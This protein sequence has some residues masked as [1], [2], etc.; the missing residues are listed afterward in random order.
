MPLI[1]T[2]NLRRL[3]DAL[4]IGEDTIDFIGRVEF[5]EQIGKQVRNQ[6]VKRTRQGFGVKAAEDGAGGTKLASLQ[7]AT[8]IFRKKLADLGKLS[9]ETSPKKSNLTMTGHMLDSLVYQATKFNVK[10]VFSDSFAAKK[11][12]YAHAGA[13]N[14]KKRIFMYLTK[15]QTK[16]TVRTLQE[17]ADDYIQRRLLSL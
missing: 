17:L 11:A 9:S 2:R 7:P 1:E 3:N 8:I 5:M 12:E 4:K 6:I 13:K 15:A 10:I 16:E 14:R